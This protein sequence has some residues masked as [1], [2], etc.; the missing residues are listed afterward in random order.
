MSRASAVN[1]GSKRPEERLLP[2]AFLFRFAVPCR[3]HDPLWSD[4]GVEL[5]EKYRLPN[6]AALEDEPG[7]VPAA[8]WADV[9]AAWSD[10][11]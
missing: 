10:A 5:G 9:R 4:K 6:F 3:Y 11:G 1:A 2:P 8:Q 7:E